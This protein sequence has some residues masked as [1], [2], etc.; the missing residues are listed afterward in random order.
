MDRVFRLG[1]GQVGPLQQS[2]VSCGAACL[3]VARM[4]RDPSLAGWVIEG[5]EEDSRTPNERFAELERTIMRRTN[6]V[7][8]SPGRLQMP[9]PRSLGTSPWGA[10][11]EL[12]A[13]GAEPGLCY[14]IIPLR[15]LAPGALGGAFDAL[16]ARVRPGAPALL[17]VG[18]DALP[19]HVCLVFAG[20]HD[21][22]VLLYEPATG[23][24]ELPSRDRFIESRL[25]LGGWDTPWFL[26][27]P[28]AG[29]TRAGRQ[30]A[31]VLAPAP[32]TNPALLRTPARFA[33][34]R[35]PSPVADRSF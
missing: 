14:R 23:S 30:R 25:G 5:R 20:L 27:A 31:R 29:G 10:A 28:S 32:R 34:V 12:E 22:T 35:A 4:M 6:S 11:A 21:R 1:L 3:A 8:A 26:V 33:R 2:A 7:F 9:W 16:L 19:R 15:G 18:S 13:H 17:Y 24:V